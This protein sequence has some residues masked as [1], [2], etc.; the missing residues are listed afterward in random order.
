MK[1][2]THAIHASVRRVGPLIVLALTCA[3]VSG[4]VQVSVSSSL[5]VPCLVRVVGASHSEVLVNANSVSTTLVPGGTYILKL[6]YGRMGAFSYRMTDFFTM[7]AVAAKETARLEVHNDMVRLTVAERGKATS[8]MTKDPSGSFTVSFSSE[9]DKISTDKLLSSIGSSADEF[10][11]DRVWLDTSGKQ[12]RATFMQRNDVA[13]T[14][15]GANKQVLT[16]PLERFS[17]ADRSYLARL[18]AMRAAPP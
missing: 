10:G 14:F 11:V 13:A 7:P 5:D 4:Q 16:I 2:I 8:T 3:A 6:R 15:L 18:P 9:P 17:E 1:P 12:L